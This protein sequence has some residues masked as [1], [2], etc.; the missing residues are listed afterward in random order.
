MKERNCLEVLD[1]DGNVIFKWILSKK[2]WG[3]VDCNHVA[4]AVV[5]RRTNRRDGTDKLSEMSVRKLPRITT[6]ESEDLTL[7]SSI[8][9]GEFLER[10]RKIYLLP[11][12]KLILLSSAGFPEIFHINT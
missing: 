7:L 8:K 11:S 12:L 3:S 6:E 2:A 4:Q 9:F 1:V 10:L 5:N